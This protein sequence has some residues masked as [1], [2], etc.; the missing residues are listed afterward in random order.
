MKNNFEEMYKPP[1]GSYKH[2]LGYYVV[3][4]LD[5]CII[6]K[7]NQDTGETVISACNNMLRTESKEEADMIANVFNKY[8]N[9]LEENKTLKK[10][11]SLYRLYIGEI[12]SHNHGKQL[13]P[14]EIIDDLIAENK[15]LKELTKDKSYCKTCEDNKF[16]QLE[17]WL[18]QVKEKRLYANDVYRF[19]AYAKVLNKIKELKGSND[20]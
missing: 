2:Q 9:L 15:S 12:P 3:R 20:D 19:T 10:E 1:F 14:L 17:E 4:P 13:N 18:I 5:W 11:L 7:V 16:N 6:G 8:F